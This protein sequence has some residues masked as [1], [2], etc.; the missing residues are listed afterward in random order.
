[1]RTFI[2][3]LFVF[4]L[5]KTE[6]QIMDDF[7]DGDFSNSPTWVGLDEW[8]I[9]DGTEKSLRL[10]APAETGSAWLFTNSNSIENATWQF[11][12]KMGFNPS[13]S[14]YAQVYLAADEKDPYQLN[15]ALYLVMQDFD[16][17]HR[18]FGWD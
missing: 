6:A 2:L 8:F 9:I 3:V 5:I 15:R 4:F 14:N 16:G 17:F 7:S 12:F 1:M 11:S 18:R 13:S 10:D